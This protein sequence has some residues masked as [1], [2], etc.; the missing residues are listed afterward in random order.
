MKKPEAKRKLMQAKV[1]LIMDQPF[2]GSLVLRLPLVED[3]TAKTMWTNSRV[4]GYNPN[5]VEKWTVQEIQ[6]VLCHEV[7]H[8]TNGHCWRRGRRDPEKW[9]IAADYAINPIIIESKMRLPESALDDP[10][11]YG[12]SAE[13]IYAALPDPPPNSGGS[14]DNQ[15]GSAGGCGEVRDDPGEDSVQAQG[16]WDLAVRQA[17]TQAKARGK[18]PESLERAVEEFLRPKIDWK[19]ILRRFVQQSARNDYSWALPNRRYIAQG[20]YLPALRSE[21][22]PP[23]VVVVDTSGSIGEKQLSS[24]SSEIASIM[25]EARPEPTHVLYSDAKVH[26]CDEFGPYDPIELK[27]IGG[28]G[29]DFRPAFEWVD[30]HGV[31]PACM[32]YLTDLCG[33]FPEHPAEYPVLWVSTTKD[34]APFGE[35]VF[36][37]LD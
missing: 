13:E 27:P 2:F 24:F 26:R 8:V 6:G 3:P 34:Q 20:L 17:A 33:S 23:I 21:Q 1:N 15:S 7:L 31:E 4:I 37:D 10:I 16:D 22:M 36:L 19:A 29:T 5:A 35:T 25:S 12:K 32:I 18:L 30:E 14:A 9:N 28:G 11:F